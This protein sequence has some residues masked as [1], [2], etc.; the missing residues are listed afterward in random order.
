MQLQYHNFLVKNFADTVDYTLEKKIEYKIA[1]GSIAC[2]LLLHLLCV[3]IAI[4]IFKLTDKDLV[5]SGYVVVNTL[6]GTYLKQQNNK[7]VVRVDHATDDNLKSGEKTESQE[8]NSPTSYFSNIESAGL[9]STNLEQVYKEH[10]LNVR[11]K[12]PVGWIYIDQQR[13]SKLDGITFW[14]TDNSFDPPP[15]IH[16]EV[17]DKYMFNPTRYK[18]THKFK[19]FEGFYNEPEEMETQITQQIYIKTNDEKDFIIKLIMN[20]RENFKKFQPIFF[21]M[22]D[23]FQFGNSFLF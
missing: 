7:E 15:Y 3:V 21:A 20:G 17:V 19:T 23:S 22:V 18:F 13:K 10:T 16:I 11:L 6:K 9:D 2:S 5:Q 1:V 8:N 14:S 12:Y 4:I